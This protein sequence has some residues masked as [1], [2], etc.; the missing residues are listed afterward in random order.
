MQLFRSNMAAAVSPSNGAFVA[1]INRTYPKLGKHIVRYQ[2]GADRT[3]FQQ[4][5]EAAARA[6]HFSR[7]NQVAEIMAIY[8]RHFSKPVE[9]SFYRR[10]DYDYTGYSKEDISGLE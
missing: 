7:Q 5:L 9:G 6:G 8:D 10:G 2:S 1:E 3:Q 4:A